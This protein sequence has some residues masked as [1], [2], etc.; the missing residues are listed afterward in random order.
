MADPY[1]PFYSNK[2]LAIPGKFHDF[3]LMEKNIDNSSSANKV[4]GKWLCM[5][6]AHI[7]WH[8]GAVRDL[9][10]RFLSSRLAS[11]G[12][13]GL[14]PTHGAIL[15]MLFSAGGKLKMKDVSD[16]LGRT[17]STVS[18]L[19]NRLE[20]LGLVKRCECNVDG[21]VC[22]VSLTDKGR[23]FEKDLAAA[24][25]ELN[26][27]IYEGFSEEEKEIIGRLILRMKENLKG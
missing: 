22:Y 2:M 26:T 5:S 12:Y 23:A 4:C 9:A 20:K 6:T 11:M 21:R 7:L 25:A 19:V 8:I 17:K 1:R 16:R 15:A 24:S 27:A 13:D 18:E 14:V 10:E 3:K